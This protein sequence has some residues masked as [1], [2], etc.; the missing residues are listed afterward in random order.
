MPAAVI[1]TYFFLLFYREGG[2][3]SLLFFPPSLSFFA[4]VS[5]TRISF[6]YRCGLIVESCHYKE[7]FLSKAD[8][9]TGEWT[10]RNWEWVS[11]G[12]VWERRAFWILTCLKPLHLMIAIDWPCLRKLVSHWNPLLT[13]YVAQFNDEW[14]SPLLVWRISLS[15]LLGE[16]AEERTLDE[17]RSSRSKLHLH[18]F[19][20]KQV[21]RSNT[22]PKREDT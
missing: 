10:E 11:K 2:L 22:Q 18:S 9:K 19:C 20:E 3:V 21:D 7:I 1:K 14:C 6:H 12:V 5:K 8:R 15:C 16:C 13:T 4:I 17:K